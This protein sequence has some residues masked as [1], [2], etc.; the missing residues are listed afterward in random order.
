MNKSLEDITRTLKLKAEPK[1]DVLSIKVGEKNYELPIEARLIVADDY[2][3]I[4]IP[5]SAKLVKVSKN[6]LEPVDSPKEAKQAL[7]VFKEIRKKSMKEAK[8]V[9]VPKELESALKG[10]PDGYKLT[11]D[12]NGEPKIVRTRN[13]G[14]KK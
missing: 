2:A 3:F 13:R 14:S 9:E 11:Y 8:S 7:S 12:K 10:L 4:H 6:E 5:P 1:N